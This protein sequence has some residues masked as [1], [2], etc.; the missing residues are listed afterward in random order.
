MQRLKLFSIHEPQTFWT[1]SELLRLVELR[2]T[3]KETT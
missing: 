1:P 2:D 3:R